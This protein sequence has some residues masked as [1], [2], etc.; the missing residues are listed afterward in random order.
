MRIRPISIAGIS[1][2]VCVTAVLVFVAAW[3]VRAA[4]ENYIY[5]KNHSSHT[6][7]FCTHDISGTNLG[8]EQSREKIKT[9]KCNKMICNVACFVSRCNN[10]SEKITTGWGWVVKF[11]PDKTYEIGKHRGSC[12]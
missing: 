10:P 5:L 7:T 11:K 4:E 3:I 1:K 2:A 9:R 8:E 12:P 6:Y